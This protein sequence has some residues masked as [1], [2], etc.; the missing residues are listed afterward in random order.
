V[1]AE[2]VA[3][4]VAAQV[5]GR[6]WRY[7]SQHSAPS[8]VA[9][10]AESLFS[11]K[12]G[13][14]HRLTAAHLADSDST[15]EMLDAARVALREL[16][17][18]VTRSEIELHGAIRPPVQWPRTLQRRAAT[19]DR[20]RFV[21]RPPERAYDTAL[22]RLILAALDRCAGL[23]HL[24]GL[25]NQGE[26]G[27]KVSQRAS[28]ASHLRSHAK[29][30][31]VRRVRRFPERT[32]AALRR[33]RRVVPVIDWVRQAAEALD[34]QSPFVVRQIVQER[35]LPPSRPEDLFELFVGFQLVD[36][37]VGQGF[38]EKGQRLIPGKAIPF[39]QLRRGEESATIYWQRS[40]W[41]VASSGESGRF[42]EVLDGAQMTRS[43]LLPDFVISLTNPDRLAF[44]EVKLTI[45]Q[46]K[47]RDR[48][49]IRDA[50]AYAYDA[51]SLLAKSPKP[52]GLV[53][54]WNAQGQPG[55]GQIEV[56]DQNAIPAAVSSMLGRWASE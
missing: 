35:L 4:D 48:D 24:A 34:D 7:V 20:Q 23:P 55:G 36:A 43:Q 51:E 45:R 40:L 25:G 12:S 9:S 30:R 31:D 29:L 13:E 11:L 44:I 41:S 47:T 53:V 15:G 50:M 19:A 32:L 27:A 56:A 52:H 2:F 54:A 26:F 21:C 3:E 5:A 42:Q 38:S 28:R 49:G 22:G 1:T 8:D 6:L 39:A 33:H 17:S 18:S 16:P 14:L 37:L 46:G 10:V